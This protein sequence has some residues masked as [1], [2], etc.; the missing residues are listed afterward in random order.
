MRL[1]PG[2]PLWQLVDF[3]AGLEARQRAGL[4]AALEASGLLDA[5]VLPDGEL[6]APGTVGYIAHAAR[7]W[8]HPSGEE[9]LASALCP[10]LPEHSPVSLAVVEKLLASIG[11]GVSETFAWVSPEGA[12]RLGPLGGQWGKDEAVYIGHAAREAARQRRLAEIAK[13]LEGLAM[14]ADGITAE[15]EHLDACLE[16]IDQEWKRRPSAQALRDAHAAEAGS[17][18][19]SGYAS[20]ASGARP[21]QT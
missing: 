18:A 1:R 17:A 4:E 7:R 16:V 21:G 12:W 3:Q 14:E 10:D 2:A 9:S 19:R 13:M 11:L 15:L 5:W 20:R 8:R 6:L